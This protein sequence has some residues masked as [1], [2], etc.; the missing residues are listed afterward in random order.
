MPLIHYVRYRREQTS[1]FVTPQESPCNPGATAHDG[2]D[3]LGQR[4]F[5]PACGL[6][7]SVERCAPLA[8][9]FFR[10][11]LV[12]VRSMKRRAASEGLCPQPFEGRD[13]LRAV[14][15]FAPPHESPL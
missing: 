5:L 12:W 14:S 15:A 2:R 8:R 7:P 13:A 11:V 10:K 1:G 9:M 6:V 3:S 4:R